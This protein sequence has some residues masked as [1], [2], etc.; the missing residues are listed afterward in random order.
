[1]SIIY[2]QTHMS[3]YYIEYT[4]QAILRV[5]IMRRETEEM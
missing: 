4:H 3:T 1:M 2:N 5:V